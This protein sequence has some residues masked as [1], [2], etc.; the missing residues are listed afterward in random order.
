MRDDSDG[1][2]SRPNS[3]PFVP[4]SNAKLWPGQFWAIPL[5]DGRFACGR[6]LAIDVDKTY[7]ARSSFVAGLLDWVGREPPNADS[8]AGAPVLEVG[9]AHVRVIERSGGAVLGERP[10]EADGIAVPEKVTRYWGTTYPVTRAE[11]RFVQGEPPPPSSHRE[12]KSPLTEE[13][14]KPFPS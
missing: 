7:G 5:S 3:Y 14:L 10:L 6:V 9:T 13:M 11:R 4:K 8:I 12:I 1:M 2:T